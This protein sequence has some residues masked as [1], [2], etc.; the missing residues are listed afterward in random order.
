V[1]TEDAV[2]QAIC[3][4]QTF[5]AES[6]SRWKFLNEAHRERY[7]RM[8]QAA[9]DA[10]HLTEQTAHETDLESG[11]TLLLEADFDV[12]AA[13]KLG[14]PIFEVRRFV[15]PWARVAEEAAR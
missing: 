3:D 5:D 6:F 8:A 10:L 13:R 15:G 7:R 4:A 12:R 11:V 2:A 9:I 14:C 1:T